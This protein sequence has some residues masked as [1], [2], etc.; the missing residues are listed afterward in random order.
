LG[1]RRTVRLLTD[2]EEKGK[3]G[4]WPISTSVHCYWCVHRFDTQPVGLPVKFSGDAFHV[5]GC[6]CSLDCACAYNFATNRD[7][8]D[9]CLSRY[10]LINALSGRMG[11]DRNVQPAPDRLAL[12]IFGGHLSIEEFRAYNGGPPGGSGHTG[13]SG[14]SGHP[15]GPASCRHLVVSCPPMQSITQQVEEI[16]NTDLCS[17]YR[18]IPLDRDRVS[19]YQ[20]KLR[21]SRSKPLVNVKN[22]LDHTMN[23]KY[24]SNF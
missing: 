23:L 17:E 5:I 3:R 14:G 12:S 24:N 21:L 15:G 4:E 6:F 16:S 22:T 10:S 2:F 20:E 13:G 19:R 18:Y 1:L 8:T 11:L 7:S 9:E